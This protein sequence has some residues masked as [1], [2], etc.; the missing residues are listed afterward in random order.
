MAFEIRERVI[1]TR[2]TISGWPTEATEAW[3]ASMQVPSLRSFL[4]EERVVSSW[5]A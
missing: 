3:R 1:V 2:R 4:A 5:R